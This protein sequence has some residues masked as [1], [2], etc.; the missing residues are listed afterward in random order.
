MTN[1][2][3]TAAG[4]A[5]TKEL[6]YS[7]I[8]RRMKRFFKRKFVVQFDAWVQSGKTAFSFLQTL[9]DLNT[10][11]DTE[12]LDLYELLMTIGEM[13]ETVAD[14]NIYVNALTGDDIN[15]LGNSTTPFATVG[16]ALDTIKNTIINHKV[17]I[18]IVNIIAGVITDYA[19]T[20]LTIPNK[21][22]AGGSLT[23]VGVGAPVETQVD[24]ILAAANA[25]G[26]GGWHFNIVAA[27]WVPNAWMS[28]FMVA[29][30]G[31]AIGYA[32]PIQQ[33]DA[34]NLYSHVYTI[35]PGIGDT[36]HGLIPPVQLI[37][38]SLNIEVDTSNAMELGFLASRVEFCNLT[39]DLSNSNKLQGLFVCKGAETYLWMDF[40]SIRLPDAQ[41]N[42]IK[43]IDC[44]VNEFLPF[45]ESIDVVSQAVIANIGKTEC[46]GVAISR[47]TKVLDATS[48]IWMRRAYLSYF[49]LPGEIVN[50]GAQ[51]LL[52]HCAFNRLI[53]HNP[54]FTFPQLCLISNGGVNAI[55]LDFA[56]FRSENNYIMDGAKCIDAINSNLW[57]GLA[58]ECDPAIPGYALEAGPNVQVIIDGTLAAFT[59]G[60]NSILFTAPNPDVASAWPAAGA[61][62]NDALIS[63]QVVQ[64]G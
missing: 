39:L 15:G 36:V 3:T 21:I 59:G 9:G 27:P 60:T 50:Y 38:D 42:D 62:A 18:R 10:Y 6:I 11:H 30:D 47:A 44:H 43:L 58:T 23:F 13:P 20:D 22:N 25:L 8:R 7:L 51:T 33:N 64:Q 56:N 53:A 37:M 2:W 46:A 1:L 63:A 52:S 35:A 16:R 40:V 34:S 31:A 48:M 5:A 28:Q 12:I 29:Q 24:Q 57:I 49:T 14:L 41:E 61:V 4:R 32:I 55:D 26:N 45:D 17:Q 19:E 54:S